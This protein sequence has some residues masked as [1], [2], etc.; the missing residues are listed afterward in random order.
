MS[1]VWRVAGTF[2]IISKPRKMESISINA[3]K[4]NVV[5]SIL[6]PLYYEF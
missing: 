2:E 5:G 4:I 3:K 6:L 1:G